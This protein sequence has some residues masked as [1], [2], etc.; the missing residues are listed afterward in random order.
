M[1]TADTKDKKWVL[2]LFAA[3]WAAISALAAWLIRVWLPGAYWLVPAGVTLFFA[4]GLLAPALMSRPYRLID[5]LLAPVGRIFALLMLALVYFGVF[6]PFAV[7]L[8]L[9][10]WDP[11]RRRRLHWG[12]SA[13]VARTNDPAATDYRWQY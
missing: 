6:T 3:S 10:R 9:L 8:R 2:R 11:L 12:H 13:W 4:A 7:V 5:R 1:T